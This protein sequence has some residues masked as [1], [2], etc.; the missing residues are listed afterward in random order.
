M[1]PGLSNDIQFI[2]ST[3]SL[4]YFANVGSTERRGLELS[5]QNRYQHL[6]WAASYGWVDA[7]YRSD[8]STAS[9]SVAS[10]NTLPGIARQTLKLRAACA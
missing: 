4:G 1:T 8:F 9:G 10:G 6:S 3:S 2:A 7:R 5:A